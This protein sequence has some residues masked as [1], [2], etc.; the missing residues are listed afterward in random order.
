MNGRS[1]GEDLVAAR[2]AVG[3]MFQRPRNQFVAVASLNRAF[4]RADRFALALRAR[5]FAWNPTLPPLAFG[6]ADYVV[7]AAAALA[8]SALV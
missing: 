1:V 4:A 2:T 3:I 5:C 7:L 6:R 8:A